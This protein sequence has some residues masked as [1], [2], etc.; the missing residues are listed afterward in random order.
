ME[1]VESAVFYRSRCE[2]FLVAEVVGSHSLFGKLDSLT[3][4][5]APSP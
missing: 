2:Q 5:A 4:R 1:G 3:V